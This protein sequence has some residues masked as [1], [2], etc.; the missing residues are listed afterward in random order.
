M[1]SE[2]LSLEKTVGLVID[3]GKEGIISKPLDLP[4][5]KINE[6][7][8]AQRELMDIAIINMRN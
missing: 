4:L 8:I 7:T 3:E 1:E 6:N 2:I 5:A